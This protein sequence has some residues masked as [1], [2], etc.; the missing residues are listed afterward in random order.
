[1]HND[2]RSALEK[3]QIPVGESSKDQ[4]VVPEV[5]WWRPDVQL[6][7]DLV[8]EIVRVMGY[9]KVPSTIPSW[10]PSQLRFDRVRAKQ[11]L[12]REVLY[13]A[14]LFEVM[15]YSFVSLEQ[16]ERLGMDVS[17]HLKL[18]N[19]L[20]SEQAY[21]RSSLL[22]SHVSVL[23]RNRTYAKAVGFYEIS[24]VFLKRGRASSRMS[25]SGWRLRCGGRKGLM[26]R[27]RVLWTRWL[28]L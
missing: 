1:L 14:G 22:P 18:K 25:R 26:L 10:R 23:E 12:V 24:N 15:T 11:R 9:D 21:L 8:E 7:E 6:P 2:A 5:P 16:L 19:P 28:G 4:I 27:L 17:R 3:L 13:G 20:S